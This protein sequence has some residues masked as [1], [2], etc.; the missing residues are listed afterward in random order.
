MRVL[1]TGL[2]PQD[3]GKTTMGINLIR[4]F[5]EVGIRMFPYKPVA[6][7]NG[8]YS[9]EYLIRGVNMGIIA[10]GDAFK[11]YDETGED[12]RKIN[13]FTL[14]TL[15]LDLEKADFRNVF[16]ENKE[17]IVHA[18]LRAESCTNAEGYYLAK[19]YQFSSEGLISIINGFLARRGFNL[20][21]ENQ[22][23]TMIDD[24]VNSTNNC[25]PQDDNIIIE[26][27]NDAAAPNWESL[28]VDFTLAVSPGKSF[29]I[30]GEE[31]SMA[32]KALT[33]SRLM[34]KTIKVVG[35]VRPMKSFSL[36][37]HN[38]ENYREIVNWLLKYNIISK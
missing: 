31:Y 12:I 13:P 28:K 26:S 24:S 10:G 16:F 9:Y 18:L 3:S 22:I 27:Y 17:G 33:F 19:E 5:K 15:P 4:A 11:Y 6:G 1:I 8:W 25:T 35:V 32:V 7:F 23:I 37:P 36:S 20:I 21:S 38:F 29:L 30:S 14:L 2:L 34:M